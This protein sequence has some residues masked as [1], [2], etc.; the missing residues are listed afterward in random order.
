MLD[1]HLMRFILP[2]YEGV[3]QLSSSFYTALLDMALQFACEL[4]T[5][6]PEG[7][8]SWTLPEPSRPLTHP[9]HGLREIAQ[10][11]CIPSQC[12]AYLSI[13]LIQAVGRELEVPSGFGTRVNRLENLFHGAARFDRLP[14]LVRGLDARMESLQIQRESSPLPPAHIEP[15]RERLRQTR[16]HLAELAQG[17]RA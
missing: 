15:W 4:R 7:V 12:G 10:Q 13:D 11:L 5:H 14:A 8:D 3:T 16:I 9:D 1:Q 17:A 2:L 6:L